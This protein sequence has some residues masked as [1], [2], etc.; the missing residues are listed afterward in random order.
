[1]DREVR[2]RGKVLLVAT[3][4]NGM[5]VHPDRSERSVF[6]KR[7]ELTD[8]LYPERRIIDLAQM[9]VFHPGCWSRSCWTGRN[10]MPPACT[11][12]RTPHRAVV[13][14]NQH[15]HRLA[16]EILAREICSQVLSNR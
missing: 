4:S 3:L 2:A 13:D 9:S 1:M 15:G 14:W 6:T 7:L 11:D 5:Q 10:G 12:S 16:G 8:L